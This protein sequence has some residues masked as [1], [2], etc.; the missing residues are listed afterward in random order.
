MAWNPK[1][2][3]NLLDIFN[4]NFSSKPYEVR[5]ALREVIRRSDFKDDF[6]LAAIDVIVER[7]LS[8]VDRKGEKFDGYSKVYRESDV[9]AIYK[10]RQR[11][12]DLKL[13]GEMLA[14]MQVRS[15][16]DSVTVSFVDDLNAAKAHGHIT[17][18][19]GRKGGV[20]RDFFGLSTTEEDALMKDLIRQYSSE[21]D[22][23]AEAR[24]LLRDVVA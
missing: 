24:K 8:G 3:L 20:V 12:V 9:F 7:T 15:A 2:K 11:R 5:R 13:S 16:G 22:L 14:S 4:R 6:G 1:L 10:G 21:N 17:G 18:M 23:A 19:S